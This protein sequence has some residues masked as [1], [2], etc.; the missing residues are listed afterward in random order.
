M[1]DVLALDVVRKFDLDFCGCGERTV[2]EALEWNTIVWPPGVSSGDMTE[3]G[4]D[5]GRGEGAPKRVL[6]VDSAGE[7][8]DE[9]RGAKAADLRGIVGNLLTEA[10]D[11]GLEESEVSLGGEGVL[12]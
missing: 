7:C 10:L 1:K 5:E 12:E 8:V 6:P 4:S 11:D 9:E 3:E 2:L